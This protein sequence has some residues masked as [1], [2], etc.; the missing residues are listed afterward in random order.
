MKDVIIIGGGPSGLSAALNLLRSGKSVLILEKEQFGGQI[1]NSPRVENLP[2]IKEISGADFASKF[3]DQV[4]E[5]GAEFELEEVLE[6]KKENNLFK[7]KTNY[8]NYE[9]KALIIASGVKHKK[10]NI[11]NEIALEGKGVSYCAVCDGAFYKDEDVC[12]VGDA[13]TALQYTLLLSNYCKHVYLYTLFDKF[14]ADKIL[15]DR[16]YQKDNIIIKHNKSLK[17]IVGKDK[18]EKLIFTDTK[19]NLDEELVV[20]GLFIAIG[21]IPQNDIFKDYVDLNKG[22]IIVN[23]KME[24]KTPGLFAV[25]DCIDKNMRQVATAVNDG[26]I[27]AFFVNYYLENIK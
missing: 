17:D 9:S 25:G 22:F 8:N 2:S 19:S 1:A 13:N 26:S 18:L 14:F 27:A 3:F 24:T 23:N 6:I 4:T 21:Q 20:K 12:L 15:V 5:L 7:V 10:F 16:I 11:P